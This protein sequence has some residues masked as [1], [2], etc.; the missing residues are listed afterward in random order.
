MLHGNLCDMSKG[1]M[2]FLFQCIDSTVYA[3]I[4][5]IKVLIK[6]SCGCHE[7]TLKAGMFLFKF[8]VGGLLVQVIKVVSFPSTVL[9]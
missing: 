3:A 4:D 7:M 2:K 6:I 5:F 1:R 9:S 8:K